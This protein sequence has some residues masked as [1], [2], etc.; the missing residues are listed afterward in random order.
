MEPGQL[1][2]RLGLNVPQEWWPGAPLVKSFEAAGF[3]WTQIHSPPE[4]VLSSPRECAAHA[5]AAGAAL[6][7]TKLGVA[8]H[9]PGSLR[10][11]SPAADRAFEGLIAYAADAGAELIVYHARNLPDAEASEDAIL[12]E[13]RSLARLAYRAER[14]GVKIAL[15]NLAPVFPGPEGLSHTPMVLRTLVRR[16]SSPAVG[17]CL[18]LGHAHVVA[19]LRHADVAELA[20]PVL[21]A[22]LLFH[23]HDNLGARRGGAP[24][25]SLDP[26]RLDLHLPPGRGTVPWDR[27]APHL[28][29]HPAPLVLEVHPPHRERAALLFDQISGLLD[30]P[31]LPVAA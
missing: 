24:S 25:G 5:A 23:V 15:E 9:A 22:V 20:L 26:L 3:G 7:T 18:D 30:R 13:T 16:L 12:A 14:L 28:L 4:S 27:L 11:G 8:V 19:D 31:G 6:A 17:L 10:A 29:G 1:A 2:T 21:D